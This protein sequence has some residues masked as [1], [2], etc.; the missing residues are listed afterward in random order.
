M[1]GFRELLSDRSD[2]SDRSDTTPYKLRREINP[3]MPGA[4]SDQRPVVS[5]G[6][7]GKRLAVRESVGFRELIRRIRRIRRT[8]NTWYD[9][10][11]P[12]K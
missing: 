8:R 5:G 10:R 12:E 7:A 1:P 11:S 6:G 9:A 3:A 4:A 2:P